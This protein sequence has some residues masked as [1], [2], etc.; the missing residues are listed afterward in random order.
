MGRSK[1]I[2]LNVVDYYSAAIL[3]RGEGSSRLPLVLSSSGSVVCLILLFLTISSADVAQPPKWCGFH[4]Q[5]FGSGVQSRSLKL[6]APRGAPRQSPVSPPRQPHRPG[7]LLLSLQ[8]Q[9]GGTTPSIV[10]CLTR[11]LLPMIAIAIAIAT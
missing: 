2:D 6:L 7:E 4:L 9:R 10:G 5:T 3:S 11:S 1:Q 8:M